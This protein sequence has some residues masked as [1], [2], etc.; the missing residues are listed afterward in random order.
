MVHRVWFLISDVGW[1]I[2]SQVAAAI[3]IHQVFSSGRLDYAYSLLAIL[4]IPF[5]IMF[6]LVARISVK[7]CQENIGGGTLMRRTA[8]PV[9]GLMLAP[10]LLFGI[11]VVLVFHGIGVPLPACWGSL[12]VDLVTFYR[13]ES[14]AEAFLNALPQ[15][16]VQSKLYLMG[17]DPNGIHVYIDTN[18]FLFSMI[19]SLFR[20]LRLWH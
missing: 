10:M 13:M 19:G 3:T 5:A 7:R 17:N 4:L 18:L 16:V 6:I 20:S 11:E 15:S 14:V 8:A 12:G 2:Y 9:I 1:F